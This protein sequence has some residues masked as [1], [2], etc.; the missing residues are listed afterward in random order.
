MD[1]SDRFHG[2]HDF[3]VDLQAAPIAEKSAFGAS[4]AS[5]FVTAVIGFSVN[6]IAVIVG[7]MIGAAGLY[8]QYLSYKSRQRHDDKMAAIRMAEATARGADV[9]GIDK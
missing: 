7:M 6:E 3:V 2:L 1:L 8:I 4:Q 5:A 9:S